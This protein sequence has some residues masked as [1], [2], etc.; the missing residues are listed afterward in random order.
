MIPPIRQMITQLTHGP[1]PP[2]SHHFLMGVTTEDLVVPIPVVVVHYRY[3]TVDCLKVELGLVTPP[4][5]WQIVTR[6]I[7]S[8]NL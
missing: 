7:D 1:L 5:R 2:V 8:G 4:L 3:T 6:N